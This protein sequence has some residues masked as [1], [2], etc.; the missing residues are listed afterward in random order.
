[1][2]KILRQPLFI[3]IFHWEYW[4][5]NVVYCPIYIYWFWLGIKARAVFFF[6]TSNPSIKNGGFLLESKK[7]IYDLIPPQYY[8]PTLLFKAGT[9]RNDILNEL[10]R[11]QMR[12]PL[13]AKPDIGM[14][15]LSVE[16][17]HC[18]AELMHYAT[19]SKVDFLI[20]EFISYENEAGI[21]YYRYP[22][23]KKGHIS[24]IVGKEFLTVTGDGMATVEQLLQQDPRF[25][26]QLPVLRRTHTEILQQVLGKD[27]THLLVPYGN[28]SRGAKFMDISYLID[29]V[30]TETIDSVCQKVP[31]FY[32]G[33]MDVR[34]N[35][36]EELRRGRNFSIIE[37]NGAGSEPTH[38][39]DP[40]HSVFYAWREIIRHLG[41]LYRI[42]KQNHKLLH[43]PYMKFSMG[44]QMLKENTAYVKLISNQ[45]SKP[46]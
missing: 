20:Q 16:K 6:S 23:E 36:W 26:L 14:R 5:F 17:V 33:R 13:I 46:A 11:T 41:I 30:L 1:M 15:G 31:G 34:Y 29:E 24:G 12:F 2:K 43:I 25:I 18:A 8:P 35:T 37:L 19:G 27:E 4:P 3:K 22:N 44:M 28:H 38:I 7:Q 32:F 40:K 39:Y 9:N 45:F 21:F 42:S 10:N